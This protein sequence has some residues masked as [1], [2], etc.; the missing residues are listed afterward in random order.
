[1]KVL[2]VDL[3]VPEEAGLLLIYIPFEADQEEVVDN[4]DLTIAATVSLVTSFYLFKH[5]IA[6]C[7]SVASDKVVDTYIVNLL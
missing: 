1:M 2:V 3:I 7:C 5:L 6:I 4:K